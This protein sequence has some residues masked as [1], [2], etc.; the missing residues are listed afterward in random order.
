[1]SGGDY[2]RDAARDRATASS[3][4][5]LGTVHESLDVRACG[6][7]H[8][9]G[10]ILPTEEDFT[11][12]TGKQRRARQQTRPKELNF[13][14]WIRVGLCLT[15]ASCV[16][17]PIMYLFIVNDDGHETG[18][19]KTDAFGPLAVQVVLL[20]WLLISRFMIHRLAKE[21]AFVSSVTQYQAGGS[22][23]SES[24]YDTHLLNLQSSDVVDLEMPLDPKLVC[25]KDGSQLEDARSIVR[26]IAYRGIQLS[27]STPLFRGIPF[28]P[29]A[30]NFGKSGLLGMTFCD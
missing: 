29:E 27:K 10:T 15:T 20:T 21:Q 1:M 26:H 4:G 23:A 16:A 17:T 7:G 9:F 24:Q 30:Q 6:L 19:N 14:R 28:L 2:D 25:P 13:I 12:F 18:V 3:V 5:L 11:W 22:I 8:V